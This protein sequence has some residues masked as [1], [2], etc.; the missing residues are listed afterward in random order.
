MMV[1]MLVYFGSGLSDVL[2]R[3][4]IMWR[5]GDFLPAVVCFWKVQGRIFSRPY[6]LW[7]LFF[8]I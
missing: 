6:Q 5:D 7:L 4:L 3:N 2:G 1:L 8:I